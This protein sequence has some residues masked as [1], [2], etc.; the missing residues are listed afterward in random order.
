MRQYSIIIPVY[1][2]AVRIKGLLD[3]IQQIEYPRDDFE[4]VVVDDASTDNTVDI[5][6]QYPHVR[7]IC[8]EKNSG[9]FRTRCTG[10]ENAKYDNLL[11][12]DSR[13]L[14]DKKIL[15]VLNHLNRNVVNGQSLGQKNETV[16][17]IFYTSI[18]RMLFRKL[19][20]SKP[21][22]ITSDNFDRLPKGTTCL[23]I[24]KH[25]WDQAVKNISPQSGELLSDDT[26]L[27]REVVNIEPILIHPDVK[28]TAFGRTEFR[29]SIRHLF[30]R[31]PKFV[32]YYLSIRN[33]RFWLV[34]GGPFLS[35]ISF[36]AAWFIIPIPLYQKLLVLL[37]A[38]SAV[39]AYLAHFQKN[40]IYSFG[41]IGVIM[42][43]CILTFY[44]GIVYGIVLKLL[45][46]NQ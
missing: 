21:I 33:N 13:A 9:R 6:E 40:K 29:K 45:H 36:A 8:H 2:E 44:S 26:K 31:G 28:I 23:F 1:N 35:L 43:V 38:Y 17:E 42:P 20:F 37:L 4:I 41:V 25:L 24:K 16:F 10:A 3:S 19:D 11:F 15:S 46:S 27:L 12:I 30:W 5:L 22:E 39:C 34:I 32:D 14:V 7:V 18:R